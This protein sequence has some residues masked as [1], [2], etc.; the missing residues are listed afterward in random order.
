MV[1]VVLAGTLVLGGWAALTH[2]IS[3]VVTNGVSMQPL[4]RAG[5][6]VVVVRSSS[7]HRG[8][9][10][11]Y[12]GGGVTILHRIIGGDADGFT[13]KGD[14]N[15]SIDP[16]HPRA[17]DLL[18]HAVLHIPAGGIWLRRLTSPP[19][20][21]GAAFMLAM[22]TGTAV[23]H[24]RRRRLRMAGTNIEPPAAPGM[25][26]A[27]AALR[28]PRLRV[29]A[30]VLAALG[31]PGAALGIAA[32]TRPPSRSVPA[33]Q[34]P[35]RT[36]T[37]SYATTVEPTAAYDGTVVTSPDPVFRT[38]ANDI[39]VTY[40]YTGPPGQISVAAR[41]SNA[42]GWHSTVPL[43]P[44]RSF[45]GTAYTGTVHLDLD[46]LQARA[47]TGAE[48][49]GMGSGEV[50]VAIVARVATATGTP[51]TP[52]LKLKL[53]PAVLTV[54]DGGLVVTDPA[55]KP[56]SIV[57]PQTLA[58]GGR[59]LVRVSTARAVSAALLLG[60]LLAIA[61]L[62]AARRYRPVAEEE[63]IQRRY[64]PLLVEVTPTAPPAGRQV[65]R[66]TKFR[67][68][69]RL[70]E[71]YSLLITHWPTED[72]TMFS[73]QDESTT[74]WYA[75]G[76]GT[77]PVPITTVAVPVA[78]P[79]HEDTP[80]PSHWE[81]SMPEA[82]DDVTDLA[83]GSLFQ[84][85]VRFAIDTTGGTRLCLMLMDLDGFT[86]VNDEHGR[87]TGDAVLIEVAER[88]R[89][90]VRPRDLV[91]RLEADNFGILLENV[92]HAAV[93]G[94]AKRIL[95][96]VNEAISIDGRTLSVQASLGIAQSDAAQDAATLIEHAGAALVAARS[97]APAQVA[98]FAGDTEPESP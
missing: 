75:T 68:L 63:D 32:W 7:Y 37:F 81:L 13:T 62:V 58:A 18:G 42:S 19:V 85:E 47:D 69:V 53:T 77:W 72:S 60:S 52:A 14:N 11:A 4:Y 98:W 1:T 48:A 57:V 27:L 82:K 89:R 78:A 56:T 76:S 28:S 16:G 36:V 93:E 83:N 30:L 64:R 10:V 21:A 15:Q 34:P 74:Y 40:A 22:G 71:R 43:S 88:L 65:V 35:A 94:I 84:E 66:V 12:H 20:L 51:F 44:G 46:A 38:V 59:D 55:P 80:D 86:A 5:D 17:A 91:A 23:R 61:F 92:G 41:L 8:Q 29:A 2:R 9:I 45:S 3:Y 33:P 39:V 87:A 50:E 90:A 67:T 31:L 26:A 24:R 49:T 54:A 70:A 6:L 73:V 97:T 95:R 79:A 25:T 96:I